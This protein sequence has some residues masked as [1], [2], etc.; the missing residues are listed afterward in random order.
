MSKPS[1]LWAAGS[2]SERLLAASPSLLSRVRP[3]MVR[4]WLPVMEKQWTGQF[5]MLRPVILALVVF[6]TT[7]KWSGLA[8]PP[9]DPWPSQYAGPLPSMTWPAA[10]VMVMS[11]PEITIGSKSSSAVVPNDVV[12]ANVTTAPVCRLCR[13]MVL[14]AGA[15]MLDS[16][17]LVH[18]LTADEMEAYAVTVHV[19]PLPADVVVDLT[20]VVD[21]L[22]DDVDVAVVALVVDVT[23]VVL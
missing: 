23:K 12:P 3:E 17:M 1:L 18:D 6:L 4:P 21:D 2:P 8:P 9:L 7:I 10:P 14:E 20:D 15:E 13:S 19:V 11:V 5:L 22:T 16:T